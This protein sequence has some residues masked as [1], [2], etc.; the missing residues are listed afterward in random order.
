MATDR[1]W[2]EQPT[3]L[4][5]R[6][7]PV[8]VLWAHGDVLGATGAAWRLL[9]QHDPQHPQAGQMLQ[10][11]HACLGRDPLGP[12]AAD[13]GDQPAVGRTAV[14]WWA[15]PSSVEEEEEEEEGEGAAHGF[16]DEDLQCWPAAKRLCLDSAGHGG[17]P[18]PPAVPGAPPPL[19]L[20]AHGVVDLLAQLERALLGA[21]SPLSHAGRGGAASLAGRQV[22]VGCAAPD[23]GGRAY[24]DAAGA[25]DVAGHA[26]AAEGT[27]PARGDQPPQPQH[28][29]VP[30]PSHQAEQAAA[31]ADA[32]GPAPRRACS[33]AGNSDAGKPALMPGAAAAGKENVAV[34]HEEMSQGDGS[35]QAAEGGD[36]PAGK[37]GAGPCA[38]KRVGYGR[39]RAAAGR[40][41]DKE[42]NAHAPQAMAKRAGGGEGQE[43]ASVSPTAS[44]RLMLGLL[45]ALKLPDPAIPAAQQALG[46][47]GGSGM[48]TPGATPQARQPGAAAPAATAT[49][50]QEAAADG[51]RLHTLVASLQPIGPGEVAVMSP[52]QPLERPSTS[53]SLHHVAAQ[54]L[55]ALLDAPELLPPAGVQ[56][57]LG[58]EALLAASGSAGCSGA[59][60]AHRSV[61]QLL[62]LLQW[63]AAQA[64][65]L[66]ASGGAGEA[67]AVEQVAAEAGIRVFSRRPLQAGPKARVGQAAGAGP[68]QDSTVS[69]AAMDTRS[70][71]RAASRLLAELQGVML[72]QPLGGAG[73]VGD[74]VEAAEESQQ[75]PGPGGAMPPE[76]LARFYWVRGHLAQS[77]EEVS[78]NPPSACPARGSQPAVGP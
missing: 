29:P 36:T 41:G 55:G 26:E 28:Q 32:G 45:A 78:A 27:P 4:L 37:R 22:V 19:A 65:V 21:A 61:T 43:G 63:H 8:Q 35:Q 12:L 57:A 42:S 56:H 53:G 66:T 34:G 14:P 17:A 76:L 10:L 54:V 58:V 67:M 9:Q 51:I 18:A 1:V 5:G 64:A 69:P 11:A 60:G 70:H 40:P 52:G 71:L 73:G 46:A 39:L 48:G 24:A 31:P 77:R 44:A 15:A 23:A 38:P 72:L 25:E 7:W 13:G 3:G 47:P 59:P 2:L 68:G 74:G 6:A 20:R 16:D 33:A 49:V 50:E 62:L 30:C 75:A